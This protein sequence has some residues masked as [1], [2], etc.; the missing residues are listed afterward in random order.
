[1]IKVGILGLG[2]IGAFHIRN[3]YNALKENVKIEACFDVVEQ[4][5]ERAGENIRRYTCLDEFF[6]QEKGR[7][8]YV[9]ICL[10]TFMHK[11][12]A[13]RAMNAGFNVLCE[14]P[15]ALNYNDSKEMCRVSEETGKKLMVAHVMRFSNEFNIVFEYIK[16]Q[17][18]GRVRNVKYSD[19]TTGLPEGHNNWFRNQQLSGG[20]IFDV[21]AHDIDTLLWFF[22]MPKAL[23]TT[24]DRKDEQIGYDSFSTNLMYDD[25]FVSINCDFGLKANKHSSGRSFR[26]NFENGYILK[27]G[28][29]FV[30][31]DKEGNETELLRGEPTDV[32]YNEIS[33]YCDCLEKDEDFERC[34]PKHSAEVIRIIQAEIESADRNGE[35]IIF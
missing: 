31:V 1:M 13:V 30:A 5:F 27:D 8:D 25:M 12:I 3:A 16:N 19:Y 29:V 14:K 26:I 2:N 33:Y 23:A 24:A 28:N 32:F 34:L 20:P 10:P 4:N 6:Q 11:D 17:T 22:G 18:F 15:M 21:H 35:K 9:D 7:L